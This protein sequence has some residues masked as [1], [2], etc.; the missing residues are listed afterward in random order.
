MSWTPQSHH[1]TQGR[2]LPGDCAG[3]QSSIL[4]P[5]PPKSKTL[6][7]SSSFPPKNGDMGYL[8]RR[9]AAHTVDE[10]LQQ[11]APG[12]M[13]PNANTNTWMWVKKTATK[14]ATLVNGTE[15]YSLR[16]PSSQILSHT[17]ML[18]FKSWNHQ[19]GHDSV[20]PHFFRKNTRFLS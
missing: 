6:R 11:E 20:H 14:L 16:N 9:Q 13:F 10:H 18:D 17:H 1:G 15:I 8:K 5:P 2:K 19:V 4:G 12:T 7:C 3:C